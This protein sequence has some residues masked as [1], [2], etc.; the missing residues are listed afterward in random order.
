MISFEHKFI[1]VHVGRTGGSSFERIAGTPI[2]DDARTKRFGNTDFD[3]KHKNFEYYKQHYPDEFTT[4]FKC[5]IVRNPYDRL[6]SAWKWQTAVVKNYKL[7]TLKDFIEA[8]PDAS[9]YS[10]KFKLE[11]LSVSES[12]KQ[13]NYIGRFEDLINTY[14]LLGEKLNIQMDAIPHTNRT[15][16]GEYQKYYN[17]DTIDLVKKKYSIDLEL[18]GYN[19]AC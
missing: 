3:E 2:T 12:I 5:T 4:F 16:I 19:F 8:R 13:F 17:E 15:G 6:V 10:E 14:Y 7:L 1:F 18:F 11:G 9:K